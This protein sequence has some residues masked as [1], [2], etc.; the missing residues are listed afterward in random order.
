MATVTQ[1]DINVDSIAERDADGVRCTRT[2]HVSGFTGAAN[3][4]PFEAETATGIPSYGSAHPSISP[5]LV[6]NKS[7]RMIDANNAHVT[8]TYRR[9][10]IEQKPDPTNNSETPTLTMSVSLVE[11]T[12]NRDA[13]GSDIIVE[14]NSIQQSAEVTKQLPL[15][16]FR[17]SRR[18]QDHPTTRALACVG[19]I[20]DASFTIGGQSLSAY[21][22]LCTS[23]NTRTDD[24]SQTFFVDYE[25]QYFAAG[26]DVTVYYIDPDTG[27]PPPDLVA[28]TGI[29][30]VAVY[31]DVDFT[32]LGI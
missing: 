19:K 25:F 13:N 31:E 5:L 23:I 10:R 24:N 32:T 29:K 14:Y 9:P 18:E 4:R 28:D 7:A 20:N 22:V 26:W 15:V 11:V 1:A 3:Q 6:V 12:S 21:T 16:T 30:V 8:V 17:L 2:F 27:R